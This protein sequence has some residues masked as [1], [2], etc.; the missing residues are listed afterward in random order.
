MLDLKWLEKICF[1]DIEIH[2]T[3]VNNGYIGYLPGRKFRWILKNILQAA[4][5]CLDQQDMVCP[6]CP[7]QPDCPFYLLN[8]NEFKPYLIHTDDNAI[9]CR[10]AFTP[11]RKC[12]FTLRIF[13][14]CLAKKET[15]VRAIRKKPLVSIDGPGNDKLIFNLS[16]VISKNGGHPERLERVIQDQKLPWNCQDR[17]IRQITVEFITPLAFKYHNKNLT[18]P[19]DLTFPVFM[20]AIIRRLDN[21]LKFH[22]GFDGQIPSTE[23][24]LQATGEIAV[25]HWEDFRFADNKA[26]KTKKNG[27]KITEYIGG[28]KGPVSFAG[29][30]DPYLPLIATGSVLHIGRHTTQ[31]MGFYRIIDINNQKIV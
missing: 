18:E 1:S 25:I 24:I 20:E 21:I 9:Q 19:K 8:G 10:G 17:P 23:T 15:I 29:N 5:P 12:G 13:G 4:S 27:G 16:S 31:G 22:C 7:F 30:L 28:P 3:A 6:P 2:Y 26:F 11:G 14:N